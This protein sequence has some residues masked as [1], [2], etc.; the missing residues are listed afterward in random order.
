MMLPLG[1]IINNIRN[2]F[3]FSFVVLAAYLDLIKGKKTVGVFVLYAIGCMMHMSAV[4]ILVLRIVCPIAKRFLKWI[5]LIPFIFSSFVVLL[6]N[7]IAFFEIG[8]FG[9]YLTKIID[10]VYRNMMERDSDYAI[11]AVTSVYQVL[12]R[13]VMIFATFLILIL[14]FY[15]IKKFVTNENKNFY[16]FLLLICVLTLSYNAFAIPYYWRFVS[17]LMICMGAVLIVYMIN[18]KK[19]SIWV[20]TVY[21]LLWAL[22]PMGLLLQVR[23]IYFSA[24]FLEWGKAILSTNLYTIFIGDLARI[25]SGI[26]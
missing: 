26:I 17:A 11:L 16:V 21:Y 12:N 8:F 22:L 15:L 19:C 5:L 1:S 2:I 25:I 9:D 4:F 23:G 14:V 13:R 3:A 10:K 24:D 18:Y 6:Y 20:K 7:H